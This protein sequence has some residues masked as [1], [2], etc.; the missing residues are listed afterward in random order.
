M[1]SKQQETGV[2]RRRGSRAGLEGHGFFLVQSAAKR[3]KVDEK[4]D[5]QASTT[6]EVALES[7]IDLSDVENQEQLQVR[8][9]AVA[10][11]LLC[12][13]NLVVTRPG[14]TTKVEFMEI[15]F[16]LQKEGFHE[17]PFTHGSEEQKLAGRWQ[18]DS[19]QTPLRP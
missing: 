14:T 16:Y 18:V 13:Y 6:T 19:V 15:E 4:E 2:K 11:A 1:T 12:D 8:F 10:K 5:Q 7:L 3:A 9:D 17:D